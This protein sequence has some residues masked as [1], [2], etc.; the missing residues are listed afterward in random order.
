MAAK[1]VWTREQADKHAAMVVAAFGDSTYQVTPFM[2]RTVV[3][4]DLRRN[5]G[6]QRVKHLCV[7]GVCKEDANL[8]DVR[9]FVKANINGFLPGAPIR[10]YKIYDYVELPDG[11][12]NVSWLVVAEDQAGAATAHATGPVGFIKMMEM[13][14]ESV[15]L[16]FGAS[17]LKK[18]K[19]GEKLQT[20]DEDELF[21]RLGA[22]M[23]SLHERETV[24]LL[25]PLQ[26]S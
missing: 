13:F 8:A 3:C 23:V 2:D 20:R 22:R 25:E 26:E 7:V 21:R 14:A 1:D 4:G 18:G 12:G 5:P 19:K 24:R 10:T 16:V 9:G 17:G 11:S 6:I 15:G